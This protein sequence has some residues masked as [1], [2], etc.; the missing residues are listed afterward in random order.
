MRSIAFRRIATVNNQDMQWKAA[1]VS[2]HKC[3]VEL[4]HD[5]IDIT[6]AELSKLFCFGQVP[7]EPDPTRRI[8]SVRAGVA[9]TRVGISSACWLMRPIQ[10]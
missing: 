2:L 5:R 10:R 1:V 4:T 9:L 6:L 3:A 8:P 7:A